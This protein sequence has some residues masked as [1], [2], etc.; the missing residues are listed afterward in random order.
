MTKEKKR[1]PMIPS[2]KLSFLPMALLAVV[3][4]ACSGVK[5]TGGGGGGGGSTPKTTFTIGGAITGLTGTGLVLVDNGNDSL[6]VAAGSTAFTF[7]TAVASGG[8]Y[9]VTVGTQP[10]SPSETCTVANGSGA[11]TANVTSVQV[12]CTAATVTVGG[13]V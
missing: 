3:M 4:A 7:K 8:A 6:T 10:S 9:A 12:T 2:K 1:T 11:A 5:G 13:T